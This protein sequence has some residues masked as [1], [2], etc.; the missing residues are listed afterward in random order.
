M[1]HAK[2]L[3]IAKIIS[4]RINDG[5][6]TSRLPLPSCFL[7]PINIFAG[8]SMLLL[9]GMLLETKVP[10]PD[11]LYT[12]PCLSNPSKAFLT[13]NGGTNDFEITN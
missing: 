10:R 7:S 9:I 12:S 4:Q 11:C 2:Y 13:V 5:T 3:E 6:Y 8:E 1:T